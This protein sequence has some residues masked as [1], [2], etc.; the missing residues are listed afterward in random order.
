MET[1]GASPS[2]VLMIEAGPPEA[3]QVN[4]SCAAQRRLSMTG[5]S[6]AV[7]HAESMTHTAVCHLVYYN[8][9]LAQQ[10]HSGMSI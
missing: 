10:Q 8:D 2:R 3:A 4:L 9:A 6:C 1:D 7:A 5:G